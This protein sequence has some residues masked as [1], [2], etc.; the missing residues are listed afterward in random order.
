MTEVVT[1]IDIVKAQIRIIEGAVIGTPE[2]G[3]PQQADIRLNGNAIQCRI[4]TEDPEENFI[5]DYG[6]IT[7]YREATGFGVRLDGGTAYAGRGDHAVLRSAARE[8]HL[9]GRR[10]P[11]RRSPACIARC[12]SSASAASR[13]IC[14]PRKHHHAPRFR[15]QPLHHAVHRHD[16]G[17]VRVPPPQGPRDQ[18]PDLHRRRHRQRPSGGARPAAAAGQT[19]SSRSCRSTSR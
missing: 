14:L 2:S 18:A 17:A 16:A 1:G 15:H 12:A 4:T 19:P 6:R 10:R 3:V 11:R 9:P 8:G 5:P 7:A 13:P